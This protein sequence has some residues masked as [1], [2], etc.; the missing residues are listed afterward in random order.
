[1][2]NATM[3]ELFD[4]IEKKSEYIFF[5]TQEVDV[6]KRVAVR[7]ENRTIDQILDEVFKNTNYSYVVNDRQVFIK[8]TEV[9]PEK[10]ETTQQN[11]P[12][13]G[14]VKDQFGEP[15]IG[16]NII[17]KNQPSIGVVSDLDG[18][19]SINVPANATLQFSYI[20]YITQEVRIA[21]NQPLHIV[22]R[23]N[24]QVMEEVVVTAL[25]IKKKKRKHWLIR[26]PK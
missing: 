8:T 24:A 25:G 18:N 3:K 7:M 13:S 14:T 12:V 10:R 6:N 11:I 9:V 26:L 16:V 2:D 19:F 5:Y 1:M 17:V 4:N 21:N 20:G 22:M 15:I 23:E